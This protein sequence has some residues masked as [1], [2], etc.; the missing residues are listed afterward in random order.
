MRVVVFL[1][2]SLRV[3]CAGVL[4]AD[5]PVCLCAFVRLCAQMTIKN[6]AGCV[7]PPQYS[8]TFRVD[9]TPPVPALVDVVWSAY[10][11]SR[12][13]ANG[14]PTL[15]T[16]LPRLQ[17]FTDACS[18]LVSYDVALSA[19]VATAHANGSTTVASD[20]VL[21][22]YNT[23]YVPINVSLPGSGPAQLLLA[24]LPE[25]LA[26]VMPTVIA[27]GAFFVHVRGWDAAGHSSMT[28]SQAVG[29]DAGFVVLTTPPFDDAAGTG[30]DLMYQRQHVFCATFETVFLDFNVSVGLHL[31]GAP[32]TALAVVPATFNNVVGRVRVC[33]NTTALGVPL[34]QMATYACTVQVSA[35]TAN[36][37][38]TGTT[39][40]VLFFDGKPT[41]AAV[42]DTMAPLDPSQCGPNA[43]MPHPL[44]LTSSLRS[45][46]QAFSSPPGMR[47][48]SVRWHTCDAP[49]VVAF[50]TEEDLPANV[51]SL[52]VPRTSLQ[53]GTVLAI[54]G[55]YLC[56]TVGT[57][58]TQAQLADLLRFACSCV[59]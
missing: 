33:V 31:A 52:E 38:A 41:V 43:P 19:A 45:Y 1:T 21:V 2:Y 10:P 11:G 26:A 32:E 8:P 56:S 57:A 54:R 58:A 14:V 24:P 17:L 37:I 15:A 6:G 12:R 13:S 44:P 50:E 53:P 16:A 35:F 27:A 46:W 59:G 7:S 23:T 49:I 30:V 20:G 25:D 22:W 5:A 48:Y 40:G 55:R 47:G 34:V 42:V 4:V 36:V 39:D 9:N 29:V 18:A 28:M 3:S 51:S